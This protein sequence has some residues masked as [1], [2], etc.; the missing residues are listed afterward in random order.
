M[1]AHAAPRAFWRLFFDTALEQ[2]RSDAFT[3]AA[4]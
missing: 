3:V 4:A 1:T 2:V